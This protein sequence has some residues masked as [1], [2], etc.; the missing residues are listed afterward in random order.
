M[1]K[2]FPCGWPFMLAAIVLTLFAFMG[3]STVKKNSHTEIATTDSTQVKKTIVTDTKKSDSTSKAETSTKTN[4]VTDNGIKITF[5]DTSHASKDPVTI[6]RKSDGTII[7]NPGGRK[8]KAIE[9][10]DKKEV[11]AST[12]QSQST[13]VQKTDSSAKQKSDSAA[14]KKVV[15]VSNTSKETTTPLWVI[16]LKA[17]SIIAAFAGA[18]Y[19]IFFCKISV[20]LVPPFITI[21]KRTA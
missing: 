10:N 14:L 7:I 13:T 19:L 6:D 15:K 9:L 17:I 18:V 21:K 1:K 5:D 11:A 20:T 2:Y 3:C 4:S 8:L 16:A 12:Q